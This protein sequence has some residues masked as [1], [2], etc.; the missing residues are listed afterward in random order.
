MI[1]LTRETFQ[2][3]T[4][5]YLAGAVIV[6]GI[7]YFWL[8][9]KTVTE[10][11]WYLAYIIYYLAGLVSSYLVCNKVKS[12]DLLTGVKS[13]IVSWIITVIG[14][15]AITQQISIVFII[16]LFI[17]MILGGVTSADIVRK[18]DSAEVPNG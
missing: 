4:T 1:K 13:A 17:L 9:I 7:V 2:P 8:E 6:Y 18:R 5:D 10:V 16:T 15:L 11:P 12:D 3:S 14:I